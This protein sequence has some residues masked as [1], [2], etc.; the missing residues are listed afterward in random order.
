[1]LF[2]RQE[3]GYNCQARLSLGVEN[4]RI[5]LLVGDNQDPLDFVSAEHMVCPSSDT[6]GAIEVRY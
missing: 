2:Y 3:E 4:S 5:I 6:I 1:M